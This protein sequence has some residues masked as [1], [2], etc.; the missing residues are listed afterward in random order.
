MPHWRPVMKIRPQIT[1]VEERIRSPAWRSASPKKR[2]TFSEKTSAT[3][4]EQ[5]RMIS[6]KEASHS[7][8]MANHWVPMAT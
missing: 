1:S 5:N 3:T 6:P 2:R 8:G 4:V 7:R